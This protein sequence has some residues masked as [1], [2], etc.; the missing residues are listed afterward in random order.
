MSGQ[1]Q[2]AE[3]LR[4]KLKKLN[5]ETVDDISFQVHCKEWAK[6]IPCDAAFLKAEWKR[7]R[8]KRGAELK[9]LREKTDPWTDAKFAL[10]G[11]RGED[12]VFLD[13]VTRQVICGP[14]TRQRL[15]QL[16]DEEFFESI[17]PGEKVGINWDRAIS[18]V[19]QRAKKEGIFDTARIRGRGAWLDR[20][21][22]MD[23]SR[24]VLHCGDKLIVDGKTLPPGRSDSYVY[25]AGVPINIPAQLPSPLSLREADQFCKRC[26]ACTGAIHRSIQ[27]CWGAGS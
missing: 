10:L 9:A 4:E 7:A 26:V 14:P 12:I 17:A 19:S 20:P 27:C 24:L 11:V 18:E 15:L 13:K 22:G 3:A 8:A 21:V 25:V 23:N 6:D 2:A 5:L 1:D 16:E